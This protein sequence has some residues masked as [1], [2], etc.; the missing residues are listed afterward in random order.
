MSEPR[1]SDVVAK[2]FAAVGFLFGVASLFNYY[3]IFAHQGI[4]PVL[5]ALVAKYREVVHVVFAPID[6]PL[7]ALAHWLAGLFHV[8]MDVQPYWKDVFVPIGLYFASTARATHGADRGWYRNAL[9]FCGI[10]VALISSIFLAS[11]GAKLSLAPALATLTAAVVLYE[12][13]SYALLL[14]LVEEAKRQSSPGFWRYVLERPLPSVVLGLAAM[15][16]FSFSA[17]ND[18]NAA[19][20]AL[21]FFVLLLGL[22]SMA[23]AVIFAAE[24]RGGWTGGFRERLFRS[25]SW[26]LGVLVVVTILTATLGVTWGG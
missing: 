1:V 20:F 13:L 11:L 21:I 8:R 17:A 5:E 15:A 22:R 25:R 23:L 3:N 18:E 6:P 7:R 12:L 14:L 2:T 4:Y 26:I 16:A 10:I 9:F 19:A 24:N